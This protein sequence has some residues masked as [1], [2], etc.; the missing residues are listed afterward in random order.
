MKMKTIVTIKGTHCQSCKL[1]IEEACSEMPGVKS[2]TVDFKTG[3]TV[4][5]HDG[6]LDLKKLK[7]VIEGLGE[8][9][10]LT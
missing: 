10:V 2:C 8:Y 4:I 1:L 3:K 5:E 7:K 9:K 6:K